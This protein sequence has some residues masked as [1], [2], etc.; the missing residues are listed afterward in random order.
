MVRMVLLGPPGAGKGTQA[1]FI[2]ERFG[3]PHISTGD[4]LRKS[5]ADQT[6]LG[7]TAIDF[8]VKGAL[9]PDAVMLKMIAER[10][11]A[12]DC[13]HGF[14]LDGFPRTTAQ[15][16]GLKSW[17][18]SLDSQLDHVLFFNVSRNTTIQ[19]LG[20]RRTCKNCGALFHLVL[21][22]PARQDVCD[23][24]QG[25]LYQREDDREKTIAAR[26]DVYENQTAPL[27]DH[28]RQQGLLREIDGI[29]GVEEIKGRVSDALGQS[30]T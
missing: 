5:V 24:C 28:Y 8:I 4:L 29:G 15:A 16:E 25:Q 14:I 7:K 2:Q 17:L 30:G 12:D 6:P 23:R 1:S 11:S 19:R 10:L 3:I 20:G 21:N 22:P 13:T 18:K 27:I 9:V 26:L